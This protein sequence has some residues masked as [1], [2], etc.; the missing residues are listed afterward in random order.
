MQYKHEVQTEH[1]P[2]VETK[3]Q[4]IM[5]QI[6]EHLKQA[7]PELFVPASATC[8]GF[9]DLTLT[10]LENVE[11]VSI[12]AQE[13]QN[14]FYPDGAFERLI[15][16]ASLYTQVN[17]SLLILHK[18][19]H[20]FECIAQKKIPHRGYRDVIVTYW[21]QAE[22]G[23]ASGSYKKVKTNCYRIEF[24]LYDD[25]IIRDLKSRHFIALSKHSPMFS[26]SIQNR[27]FVQQYPSIT[28]RVNYV[29]SEGDGW[30]RTK[31]LSKENEIKEAMI[32]DWFGEPLLDHLPLARKHIDLLMEHLILSAQSQIVAKKFPY[33]LKGV[34]VVI[35]RSHTGLFF[36]QIDQGTFAV[37]PARF[38]S[39]EA[40][41]DKLKDQYA[42][43]VWLD[44]FT[45][46]IEQEPWSIFVSNFIFLVFEVYEWNYSETANMLGNMLE[47]IIFSKPRQPDG[48]VDMWPPEFC[49]YFREK[50]NSFIAD[51][52]GTQTKWR[53]AI[54][55]QNKSLESS[56][57]KSQ[58]SYVSVVKTPQKVQEQP[59]RF[60]PAPPPALLTPI[61]GAQ[62]RIR[63]QS[64]LIPVGL[65]RDSSIVIVDDDDFELLDERHESVQPSFAF[66]PKMK[67]F[68][69]F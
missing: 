45:N 13:I 46:K 32:A 69:G 39:T 62:Q 47:H 7:I 11:T 6:I 52:R 3:K 14:F 65:E 68:F 29:C 22:K 28:D 51:A 17:A 56:G 9:L 26:S 18:R 27:F 67:S 12:H 10:Q 60:V 24:E 44:H 40:N 25:G 37:T 34:N 58:N 66:P 23:F 19:I 57:Q 1:L 15:D 50:A 33:D 4:T 16:N 31:K 38:P 43:S 64:T 59:P 41:L 8:D 49:K 21:P 54:L 20:S 61:Q 53:K 42:L 2:Q 55:A 48:R 30:R 5:L 63:E 36:R 35:T